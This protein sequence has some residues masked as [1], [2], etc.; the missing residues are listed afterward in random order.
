MALLR[1]D[2]DFEF[3]KSNRSNMTC[4]N[5]ALGWVSCPHN[6]VIGMYPASSLLC[7]TLPWCITNFGSCPIERWWHNIR[8]IDGLQSHPSI[9]II[10][11]FYSL[12]MTICPSCAPSC[13]RD[14]TAQNGVSAWGTTF[15]Q[16]LPTPFGAPQFEVVCGCCFRSQLN[17]NRLI[18]IYLK[19]LHVQQFV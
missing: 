3:A 14:A 4:L 12:H 2:I 19:L 10:D 18:R 1:L 13:S 9:G 6:S 7:Q 15:I 17:T 8:R 11:K 16:P 5:A